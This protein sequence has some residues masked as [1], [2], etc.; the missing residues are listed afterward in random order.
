MLANEDH[1][2]IGQ[3]LDLFH[4]QEEARGMVFWHPRGLASLSALRQALARVA[5]RDGFEQVQTPQ[6]LSEAVWHTSGHAQHFRAGMFAVGGV[7]EPAFVKPVSCPG[8][9][10]IFRRRAA[11]YRD[12]PLRYAEFGLVHRSEPSGTLHGLFRLRQFTQDDGH[13]FCDEAQIEAE[14]ARFCS[15]LFR[16]YRAL[17]FDEIAVAFASRPAERAG[18]DSSWDRAESALISAARQ[19][20]IEPEEAKG[21]GAFYGPKLEFA[22]KDHVGRSWQCGTIQLDLVLPERFDV[23]YVA[24]SGKRQRPAMLHRA[25]LGSLERFLGILLEHRAGKLPEWLC[26]E[27][28][29]VLPVGEAQSSGAAT[30]AGELDALGVRAKVDARNESLAKRVRDAHERAVPFVVTLGERELA[31]GQVALRAGQAQSVLPR[32]QALVELAQ[33]CRAAL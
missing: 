23:S 8:H 15:S 7:E 27:Q 31:S 19:A 13:V 1:R 9:L 14:V 2:Q 32:A 28:V 12:L 30:F 22:L 29:A 18:S 10:E 21:Q 25:V 16:C 11:S 24:G 26:P 3:K 6:I 20:G 4:F 5:E 33:R 17:G